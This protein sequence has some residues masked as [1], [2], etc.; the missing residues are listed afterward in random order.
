MSPRDEPAANAPLTVVDDITARLDALRDWSR[1]LGAE[2]AA[3][4][5]TLRRLREGAANFD[6]VGRRL[7]AASSS[8]EEVTALYQST[9]ADTTRRSAEAAGALRSQ[10]DSLTAAAS[11]ER[12]S[13]TLADMQ[14]TF[15]SLAELNPLWPKSAKPKRR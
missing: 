5:D 3:F 6:L 14:R 10:I 2:L 4:P 15:E 11:P 9:I 1:R 12:V 8:L 13:S 7:E